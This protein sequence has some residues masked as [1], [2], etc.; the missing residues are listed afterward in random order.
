[1]GLSPMPFTKFSLPC[2]LHA[3]WVLSNITSQE[4][5]VLGPLPLLQ[6]KQ[7][8]YHVSVLPVWVVWPHWRISDS[9]TLP[10]PP[11]YPY[12]PRKTAGQDTHPDSKVEL[13]FSTGGQS[14]RA[15]RSGLQLAP[16]LILFLKNALFTSG[17]SNKWPKQQTFLLT[18]LGGP[19]SQSGKNHWFPLRIPRGRPS[20]CLTCFWRFSVIP[21]FPDQRSTMLAFSSIAT[22]NSSVSFHKPFLSMS[23]C[24]N[25]EDL[26]H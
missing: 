23:F 18:Q 5:P 9:W 17:C 20:K 7:R 14:D 3:S 13:N 22:G 11:T 12:W 15:G 19:L 25:S 2:L 10:H 16:G 4:P 8:V 21:V 6:S 26:S 24:A 1:M